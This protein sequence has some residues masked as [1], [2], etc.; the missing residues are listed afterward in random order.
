[1]KSVF[2]AALACAALSF[3]LSHGPLAHADDDDDTALTNLIALASQRLA[4]AEPVA[5]WKWVNH[6]P[7][8]D[9]SR[10]QALLADM[11]KRGTAA[12]LDLSF[13]QAFFQDQIDASKSV[14]S[15][16]FDAWKTAPPTGSAPDLVHSTRPQFDRLDRQLIVGLVRVQPLRASPDCPV[17]VAQGIENWKQLTRYDDARTTALT[18]ALEHVCESGGVGGT[19]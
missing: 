13:V 19:A 5:H 1:M 3:G 14:Q 12:D 4:L 8:S 18:Q 9:T 17:L 2:R 16:L 6:R 15:E 11:R 10:E 7:V